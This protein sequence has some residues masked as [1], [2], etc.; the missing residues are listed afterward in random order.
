MINA[1]DQNWNSIA[2]WHRSATREL[3]SWLKPETRK[4]K[5][6]I[7]FFFFKNRNITYYRLYMAVI[8]ILQQ[9]YKLT[10]KC[11]L[12]HNLVQRLNFQKKTCLNMSRIFLFFSAVR[13]ENYLPIGEFNTLL[14]LLILQYLQL[15]TEHFLYVIRTVLQTVIISDVYPTCAQSSLFIDPSPPWSRATGQK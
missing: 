12:E 2:I 1:A 9:H 7:F 15:L 3:V 5:L 13:L 4:L 8:G 11:T 14:T 6:F 10:G